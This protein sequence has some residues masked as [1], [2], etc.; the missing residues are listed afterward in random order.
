[1]SGQVQAGF[2]YTNDDPVAALELHGDTKT[3]E[4]IKN[5]PFVSVF[6][7]GILVATALPI[8]LLL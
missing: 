5:K 3:F 1:M 4:T 7:G 6:F 2:A 8:E